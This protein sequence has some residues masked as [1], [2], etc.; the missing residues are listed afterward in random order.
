MTK[1]LPL[2]KADPSVR[3]LDTDVKYRD[4]FA[5]SSMVVTDYSSVAFDFAYLE[6][7]VVYTQFDK[8]SFFSGEH[9]YTKGYFDYERDGLGEVAYDLDTTVEL[10]IAY[11]KSGCELKPLY[12][13]R[14]ERFYA[15]HDKKNCERVY[16]KILRL[17]GAKEQENT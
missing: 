10:I 6:K 14:I 15:Y 13:E 7:P 4:I 12:R 8:N 3:I 11:M 9:M 5:K 1:Y 2:F 17:T 16:K